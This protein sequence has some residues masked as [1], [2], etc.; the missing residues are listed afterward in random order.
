V[1]LQNAAR[2]FAVTPLTRVKFSA[3][4]VW[5]PRLG[6]YTWWAE[7]LFAS[8]LLSRP[9]SIDPEALELAPRHIE[10]LLNRR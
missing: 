1:F 10:L 3:S 9:E 5:E 6:T 8:P 4:R 7:P 2:W